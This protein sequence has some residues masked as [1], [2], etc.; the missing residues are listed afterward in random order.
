L[1]FGVVVIMMTMALL[2]LMMMTVY[3][4]V[5]AAVV[6]MMMTTTM[7]WWSYKAEL[8]TLYYFTLHHLCYRFVNG[9]W[10]VMQ[11]VSTFVETILP[12][13]QEHWQPMSDY[14]WVSC[15]SPF[16]RIFQAICILFHTHI[17]LLFRKV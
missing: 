17:F 3:V 9:T 10:R 11:V 16:S 5:V 6:V 15:V 4:V 12:L 8:S 7:I 13:I 14:L 2:L 1:L